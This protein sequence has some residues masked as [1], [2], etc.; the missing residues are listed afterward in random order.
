MLDNLTSALL[1]TIIT[2]YLSMVICFK[3]AICGKKKACHIY[4]ILLLD[5]KAFKMEVGFVSP[6][7]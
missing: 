6:D 7:C 1:E 4:T 3:E 5:P 2:D